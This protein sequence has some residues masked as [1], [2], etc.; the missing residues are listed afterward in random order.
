MSNLDPRTPVVIGVAQI[1]QRPDDPADALEAS[2]L[3]TQAVRD[4]ADDAGTPA[5]LTGLDLI[6]VVSGAW[7]YSDPGRLVADAVGASS[8]RTSLSAVGG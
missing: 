8:A 5:A 6:G 4:A 3:M 7:K 1:K 2:A